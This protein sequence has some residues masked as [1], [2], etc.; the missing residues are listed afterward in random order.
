MR[1]ML[2]G[3]GSVHQHGNLMGV[4]KPDDLFD[5]IDCAERIGDLVDCHQARLFVEHPFKERQVELAAFIERQN[6]EGRAAPQAHLL[7]GNIVAVVL[8]LRNDDLVTGVHKLLTVGICQQID[9]LGRAAGE[10][11]L[12]IVFRVDVTS[13]FS[14][15]RLV[16][17]GGL[18]CQGVVAAMDI[19]VEAG[20][21][22]NQ[23][24]DHYLWFLRGGSV[25]KVDQRVVINGLF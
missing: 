8:K 19:G 22:I 23:R 11:H 21:I 5:W 12:V 7:P 14:P 24:I 17:F 13:H 16:C 2:H 6:S 18:H 20:V 15:C 9:R 4:R 10:D 1:E 3:L 25:V